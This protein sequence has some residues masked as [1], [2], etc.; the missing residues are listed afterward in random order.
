MKN[1]NYFI[2]GAIDPVYI[3]EQIAAHNTKHDIGA[4][5]IFLGQVRA[6]EQADRQVAGI[7]YSAYADMAIQAFTKIRE[8]AFKKWSLNCLHIIHSNGLVKTGEL[9]LFVFCSSV[10]RIDSIN[11]ME[12]IVEDIKH[13]VPIWKKEI[14]VDQS[15]RWVEA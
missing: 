9:S 4:H 14:M 6:D 13:T 3:G 7:E 15:R 10:H 12:Q 1:Q 11:A 5:A 8:Q 2:Q